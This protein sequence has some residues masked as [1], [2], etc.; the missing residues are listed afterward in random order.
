LPEEIR[1]ILVLDPDVRSA[2]LVEEALAGA[3]Y[4]VESVAD[5]AAAASRMREQPADLL[6]VDLAMDAIEPVP[7]W[8]R[9][10]SDPDPAHMPLM[11][12]G[13]AI[14]CAMEV[15]RA[16][17]RYP[18]VYLRDRK[19]RLDGRAAVRF[20]VVGS[21]PKPVTAEHL[22]HRIQNAFRQL[23]L[24]SRDVARA[25][26]LPAPAETVT[27]WRMPAPRSADVLASLGVPA[28]S[29]ATVPKP[30]R[31]ALLMDADEGYRGYV[32][33]LLEA[34]D[35]DVWETAESGQALR[36]A[37][38]KRPWLV[39][40]DVNLPEGD[41]FDL[42]RSVRRHSLI[43]H[44]PFVFLSAWDG[45]ED[46]YHALKLG[47]D[48]YISKSAPGRELLIR[49][50][51]LLKRYSDL[52]TRTHRGAGMEGD[53]EL[54]G[55]TS[56][57]QICH[58]GQF[59]GTFVGR[60]GPHKV[61]IR[62]RDGE[63]IS[64]ECGELQDE[65]AVYEFLS[66]SQGRFEFVPRDAPEARA[67]GQNFNQLLLEGCRLLDERAA[68]MAARSSARRRLHGRPDLTLVK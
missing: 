9:R 57:L 68:G 18:A 12:T 16:A 48:D 15:D 27:T 59:T 20:G 1:R 6:L 66:W 34:Q 35:F 60:S 33:E 7:R 14:L 55:A 36:L 26:S 44:T 13:Y 29:F 67:L 64:A 58:V 45:Y 49:L 4:A 46:R 24:G 23:R 2:F 39:L 63:V 3:G 10:K 11:A 43:S 65:R 22:Q 8:E 19:G 56:A 42:C 30:L 40:S 37:L 5:Q 28:N 31:K 32:R 25:A 38:D 17:A 51:L 62:F 54:I 47:A 61:E 21:V 50:Q 52:H 53:L 41:G